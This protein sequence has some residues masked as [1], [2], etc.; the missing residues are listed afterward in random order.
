MKLTKIL[1][2]ITAT[3]ALANCGSVAI[4]DTAGARQVVVVDQT[5]TRNFASGGCGA[6]G[7]Q[8]LEIRCEPQ[9]QNPFQFAPGGKVN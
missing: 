6:P 2:M 8:S 3:T 5:T 4:P 1:M 9:P 7:F